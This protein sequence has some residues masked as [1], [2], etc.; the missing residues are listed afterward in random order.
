PGSVS[1]PLS[2]GGHALTSW[3]IALKS[4]VVLLGAGALMSFRTAWSLLLG[5]LLTYA[6]LA[7]SLVEQGIVG[8]VTYKA[9]VNWTLW[10]GAALLV[11]SGLTSFALDYKS[12]YRSFSGLANL[13][14][15]KKV[16]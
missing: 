5:G 13:F 3:T 4:E 15:K 11:A 8:E 9:I 16:S 6:V 12:V 10:P 14:R 1:L 2:I 7:P